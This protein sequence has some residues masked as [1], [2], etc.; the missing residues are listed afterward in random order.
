[1]EAK[2]R[3]GNGRSSLDDNREEVSLQGGDQRD[4]PTG[5]PIGERVTRN[6]D[7][8]VGGRK[9]HS[10]DQ[11]EEGVGNSS[12]DSMQTAPSTPSAVT[13]EEGHLSRLM[14]FVR[15]FRRPSNCFLFSQGIPGCMQWGVIGV[16]V[17][18]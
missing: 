2:E 14:V 17:N 15:L 5:L 4:R 12:E 8:F 6:V 3:T 18:E 7:T 1:M 10:V 11:G 9:V 16:F 13:P